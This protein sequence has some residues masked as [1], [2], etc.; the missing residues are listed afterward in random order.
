MRT[1]LAMT[2]VLALASPGCAIIGLDR[3]SLPVANTVC[4]SL[5]RMPQHEEEYLYRKIVEQLRE[6]GFAP[7]TAACDL[8]I[9]YERFAAVQGATVSGSVVSPTW[10]EE[11][12]STLQAGAK[13]VFERVRVDLQ[14]YSTSQ[15]LLDD[16]ASNLT[17]PVTRRYQSAA[18]VK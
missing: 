14:G 6:Y 1:I 7:S 4:V 5:K 10:N 18:R 9:Q 12:L 8:T 2:F 11:G 17:R 3:T 15:Y 16:L 13:L